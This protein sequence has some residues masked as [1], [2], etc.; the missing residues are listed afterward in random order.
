MEISLAPLSPSVPSF[1]FS[2]QDLGK[3][4][5]VCPALTTP[6][7][8]RLNWDSDKDGGA[9]SGIP[10]GLLSC[11]MGLCAVLGVEGLW[12]DKINIYGFK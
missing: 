7:E 3:T 6:S 9:Q 11:F 8:G 1:N 2:R 12:F 10:L 5:W 4:S